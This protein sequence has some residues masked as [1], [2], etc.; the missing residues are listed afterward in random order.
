M[1]LG[2]ENNSNIFAANPIYL[3]SHGSA[4]HGFV[5]ASHGLGDIVRRHVAASHRSVIS[6]ARVVSAHGMTEF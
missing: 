6:K 2:L 1:G 4:A 5:A 3:V